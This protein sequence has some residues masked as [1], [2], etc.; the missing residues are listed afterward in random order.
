MK[1][2]WA[3]PP[4]AH[5]H[6]FTSQGILQLL[7]R[8]GFHEPHLSFHERWDVNSA[9]DIASVNTSR[10]LGRLRRF[11]VLNHVGLWRKAV[12]WVDILRRFRQL[13]EARR[14]SAPAEDRA[15]L[16]VSA[17]KRA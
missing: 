4:V 5:I 8:A 17:R 16:M 13:E 9:S 1:W 2:V 11:P 12:V 6:H 15:E 3:Q 10:A 14:A 7:D